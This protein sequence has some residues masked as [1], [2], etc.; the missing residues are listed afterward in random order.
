MLDR[1]HIEGDIVAKPYRLASGVVQPGKGIHISPINVEGLLQFVRW[2][3]IVSIGGYVLNFP[4]LLVSLP[5]L[6]PKASPT[7]ALVMA[8]LVFPSAPASTIIV[9]GR[10]VVPVLPY[11]A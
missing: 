8:S 9:P 7:M 10:A 2:W 4:F 6:V 1:N 11:I 5:L 3:F